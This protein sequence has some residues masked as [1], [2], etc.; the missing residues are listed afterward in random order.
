MN[1]VVLAYFRFLDDVDRV[2]LVAS[3]QLGHFP[4]LIVITR[5]LSGAFFHLDDDKI[6]ESLLDC[7]AQLNV[8]VVLVFLD[9]VS[10]EPLVVV[11]VGGDEL[12]SRVAIL[13]FLL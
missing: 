7:V 12:E 10:K 13:G 9:L 5:I 11:A 4:D 1:V 8:Q 6:V 3:N 2:I